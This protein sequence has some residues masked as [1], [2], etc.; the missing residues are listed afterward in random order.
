[1]VNSIEHIRLYSGVMY[2][3]LKD[4]SLPYQPAVR[5]AEM[6][7]AGP[8]VYRL[9]GNSCLSGDYMGLWSFDH[10]LQIGHLQAI[11]HV[12]RKANVENGSTN[13][14]VFH[15]VHYLRAQHTGLPSESGTGLKN[16]LKMRIAS[17]QALQQ[18]DKMLYIIILTRH[19]M[20]AS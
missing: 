7:D 18:T 20:P 13:A 6:G 4:D 16:D 10:E 5:G 3:V 8:Y 1:M 19:Q 9:G 2:H 17:L 11:R 14:A 12:A 15:D